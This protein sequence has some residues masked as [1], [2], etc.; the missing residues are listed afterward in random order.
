MFIENYAY[1]DCIFRITKEGKRY[2]AVC[3]A[4]IGSSDSLEDIKEN[5][6]P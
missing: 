1:K 5:E 4:I 6:I 2:R 3:G